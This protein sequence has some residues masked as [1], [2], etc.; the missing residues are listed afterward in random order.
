M[1]KN[2]EKITTID[3]TTEANTAESISDKAQE[4]III[5]ASHTTFNGLSLIHIL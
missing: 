1:P 2:T 4:G 5:N 3:S